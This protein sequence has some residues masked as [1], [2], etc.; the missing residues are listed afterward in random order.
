MRRKLRTGLG[1]SIRDWKL[2]FQAW[3]LLL[4]VDLALRLRPFPRVRAWATAGAPGPAGDVAEMQRVERMVSCAARHHLYPMRC[5]RRALVLQRLLW[6]RGIAT[7]LRLGVAREGK[8]LIAH[9][10]LERDGLPVGEPGNV[11]EHFTPLAAGHRDLPA[12]RTDIRLG[13]EGR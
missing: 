5:L 12:G 4:E 6:R 13:L 1:F 8:E 10:W 11:A 7:E 3:L 2:L 9:A